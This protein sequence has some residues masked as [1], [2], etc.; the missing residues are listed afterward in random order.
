MT[1]ERDPSGVPFLSAAVKSAASANSAAL[2]M[3][4]LVHIDADSQVA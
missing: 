4:E 1:D 3:Q 2:A